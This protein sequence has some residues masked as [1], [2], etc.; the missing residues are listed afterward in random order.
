MFKDTPSICIPIFK[1]NTKHSSEMDVVGMYFYFVGGKTEYIN[2]S[3]PDKISSGLH[4]SDIVLHPKSIVLNKKGLVYSQF[5]YGLDLNSYLQ[6]YIDDTIKVDDFYPKALEH[7]YSRLY[8]H[9]SVSTI[10]PLSK[11]IEY[12]ENIILF[13]LPYWKPDLIS[14]KCV[15]YCDDFMSVFYQIEKQNVPVGDTSKKQ[16]YMW[17]TA[18]SRP[19]NAWD[20]FNFSALNKND[21]TRNSIHSSFDGGKI[22]QFDYDAFHI[23]ILAKILGYTFENHPYEQIKEE[24]SLDIPYD[25]VKSMVFQN[26]YGTI[27][28]EFMNHPFFLQVQATID[29]LYENYQKNG[30]IESWFYNKRFREI[31]TPTPNKVFN[32]FLQSL[33]TEYNVKKIQTIFGSMSNMK[34]KLMMY[35]YD[36][37][38]F[39]MHPDEMDKIPNLIKA[40]ETDGMSVKVSTGDNFGNLKPYLYVSNH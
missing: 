36:A 15:Q 9:S 14:D 26:M 38:I 25:E 23:K 21:G 16:N 17:F 37:F 10:I 4:L 24:L 6:Y 18:T 31:D 22:V 29:E 7:F 11:L 35:L 40:F 8:G 33:E 27:T 13:T 30:Y 34:S 20:N 1:N 2:F 39:D 12:A 28:P 19:S 32:Y 3:H 5:N